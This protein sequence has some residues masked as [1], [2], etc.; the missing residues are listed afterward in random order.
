MTHHVDP[1]FQR[2][3]L[4]LPVTR[5]TARVLK[6]CW[7]APDSASRVVHPAD[8]HITLHF[9]G[10]QTPHIIQTL[11]EALDEV[12]PDCT[13]CEVTLNRTVV[14][15]S[16]ARP[17]LIAAEVQPTDALKALHA[18]T[19]N[20]LAQLSGEWPTLTPETRPWRPH[21][22][23]C[24]LKSGRAAA[25]NLPAMQ[26]LNIEYTVNEARLYV[27]QAPQV[28]RYKVVHRWTLKHQP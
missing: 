18:C 12:L 20:T 10:D 13:A 16:P 26:P 7:Q 22:T 8:Y 21:V 14:F 27:S 25:S 2:A 1:L 24:W 23:L 15:P 5:D 6:A 28:P 19:R 9:L 17:R 3:F 4:A 11:V